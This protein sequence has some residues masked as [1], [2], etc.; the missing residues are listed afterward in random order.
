MISLNEFG[1]KKVSEKNNAVTFSVGPLPKGYGHTLG[2]FLRR[3]LLTSIPGSAI[4]SV[5]IE[6]AQHEY[7]TM[8]GVPD[9]ILTILLSIKNVIVI[10]KTLEP[11][12]LKIDM[13]GK[14]GQVVEVKASD[15]EKDS[16]I[17]IVNPEYVITRLNSGKAKFTAEITV[18]R[19]S[20]YSLP[21]EELRKEISVLPLDAAFS[22][23]RLVNYIIT[24]ARVGRETDLDQLEI[25]IE[26]NGSLKAEEAL[27]IATDTINQMTTHL[28]SLTTS[29][30]VGDEVAISL[31]EEQKKTMIKVNVSEESDTKLPIKVVDLNLSTRLTNSLLKSGYDDLRKLE[32]MTEEELSN[33]RGM[34]SKSFIELLEIL[35]KHTIKLI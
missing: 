26:T 35:K 17:E 8:A 23:V 14:D 25:S 32:G 16:N 13:K 24:S 9:D 28:Q 31:N 5:K 29:L 27:H 12:T 22:P 15:I 7:S 34:G 4:T 1:V 33:I 20:G 10:S 3:I 6:G 11:V 2:N 21:K 18:E 19:G 30:L